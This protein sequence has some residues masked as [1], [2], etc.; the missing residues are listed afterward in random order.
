MSSGSSSLVNLPAE[1][2]HLICACIDRSSLPS[3]RRVC[4]KL[5]AIAAHHLFRKLYINWLPESIL[6]IAAVA[7]HPILRHHVKCMV[8]EINLLSPHFADFDYWQS[9]S[10]LQYTVRGIR[11]WEECKEPEVGDRVLQYWEKI[12]LQGLPSSETHKKSLHSVMVKL[13][14]DQRLLLNDPETSNLLADA[15]SSL[16]ALEA[17]VTTNSAKYIDEM[18]YHIFDDIPVLLGEHEDDIGRWEFL[19]Y[20][21]SVDCLLRRPFSGARSDFRDLA[22]LPLAIIASAM[23]VAAPRLKA[24]TITAFL[25]DFM[26]TGTARLSGEWFQPAMYGSLRSIA[27]RLVTDDDGDPSASGLSQI[28]CFLQNAVF[29]TDIQLEFG[30]NVWI[31]DGV[32]NNPLNRYFDQ[33]VCW[34]ISEMMNKIRLPHLKSLQ[35]YRFCITEDSFTA[36]MRFHAQ[37]LRHVSF[38]HAHMRSPGDYDAMPFSRWQR[39]ITDIAPIMSL[40]HVDLGLIEDSWL[41][42]RLRYEES[43]GEES[44]FF[45]I[46]STRCMQYLVYCRQVFAYLQSKGH[47]EYPKFENIPNAR[48][49]VPEE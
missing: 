4:Q 8:F 40:N 27:L 25:A 34:N 19:S 49:M 15:M 43:L 17:I 32:S 39:A 48:K 16:T 21:Q 18:R 22:P 12:E 7:A 14:H 28:G 9:S 23:S 38:Y 20:R 5:A 37:T 45:S 41:S 26:E 13:L 3:L 31:P 36:F 29:L 47:I 6:S 33:N 10:D 24:L 2:W 11:G 46:W 42:S 30:P 1:M 35:V 44:L